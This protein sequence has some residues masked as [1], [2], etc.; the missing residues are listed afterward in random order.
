[1]RCVGLLASVCRVV[2]LESFVVMVWWMPV[3]KDPVLPRLRAAS[4]TGM[5][6]LVRC[7]VPVGVRL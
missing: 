7:V 2:L 4:V 5:F 3:R 6:V 1:M